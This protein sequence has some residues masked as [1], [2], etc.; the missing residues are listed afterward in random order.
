MQ[1]TQWEAGGA[2]VDVYEQGSSLEG[3]WE[4]AWHMIEA[5]TQME[6]QQSKPALWLG[7]LEALESSSL[8]PLNQPALCQLPLLSHALHWGIGREPEILAS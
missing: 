1:N 6:G 7:R 8:P 4:T 5:F 2:K 3:V